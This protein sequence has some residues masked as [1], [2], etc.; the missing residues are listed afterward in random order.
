[1]N[2]DDKTMSPDTKE[3]VKK[4]V[5]AV[6]TAVLGWL[7]GAGLQSCTHPHQNNTTYAVYVDDEGNMWNADLYADCTIKT[8]RTMSEDEFANFLKTF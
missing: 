8:P 1:M 7:S 6:L 5:I 4:I 2:N 3:L